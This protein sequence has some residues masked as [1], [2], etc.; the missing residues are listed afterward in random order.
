MSELEFVT[1][2]LVAVAASILE[3]LARTIVRTIWGVVRPASA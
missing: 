2:V 3:K 1:A